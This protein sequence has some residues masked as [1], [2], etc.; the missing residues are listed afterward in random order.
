M[1]SEIFLRLEPLGLE[2]V[3]AAVRSAGHDVRV[4]DLQIFDHAEY[5]RELERFAPDAVAFSLNYLANVPEVIDLSKET[6]RRR[7]STFVFVGGH[8]ASFIARE[9]LEH[10][11]GAID[12]VIRGEGEA[13]TPMLL[14]AC[15]DGQLETLPGVVTLQGAGP[16]PTMLAS[17]DDISV[18]ADGALR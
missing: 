5:Y 2:R 15:R 7:P 10:A 3:A 14:A 9:I 4:I 8:S 12:C 11:H 18:G 6:R 1:Y 13:I 16:S 17:L